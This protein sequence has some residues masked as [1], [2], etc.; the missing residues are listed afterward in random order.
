MRFIQT[1]L[2][3]LASISAFAAEKVTNLTN[4]SQ[5]AIIITQGNA[6][7][8]SYSFKQKNEYSVN[9]DTYK[10]NGSSLNARA[11]N[12]TTGQSEETARRWDFGVRYDRALDERWSIVLGYFLES[13]FFAGYRQRHNSDLG[14][15]YL[16][17]KTDNY[18]VF[19]EV[20]YRYV[21]QNNIDGT[22]IHYNSARLYLENSYKFNP[23]NTAKLWVEH[24]PNFDNSV[25]Y[26]TNYEASLASALNSIFSLKL[27]Y[28]SKTD[29]LPQPGAVKT[30]S[31]STVSLVA[32]F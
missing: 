26:Q 16:I 14:T 32:K 28:L 31:A 30:D 3:L 27:A 23:T 11:Q 22:Q 6:E 15:K 13:D 20:G 19:T 12:Q 9:K 8:E 24:I 1:I 7:T 10:I 29:N 5:V 17:K 21:H 18:E 4:E 2:L 25:D